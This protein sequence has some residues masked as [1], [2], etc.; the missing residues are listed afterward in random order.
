M[1]SLL[2]T[3]LNYPP[4]TS[5]TPAE[6]H[7]SVLPKFHENSIFFAYILIRPNMIYCDLLQSSVINWIRWNS[8]P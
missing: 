2:T 7:P 4:D 6:T 3:S 8:Q 1:G 5:H